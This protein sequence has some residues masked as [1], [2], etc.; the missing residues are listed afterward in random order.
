MHIETQ[1]LKLVWSIKDVFNN[2]K[3]NNLGNLWTLND[4]ELCYVKDNKDLN[5]LKHKCLL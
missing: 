4:V 1:D 5:V 3:H 2:S